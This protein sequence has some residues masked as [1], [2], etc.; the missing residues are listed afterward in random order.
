MIDGLIS[1]LK[2]IQYT[3]LLLSLILFCTCQTPLSIGLE[4]AKKQL[5]IVVQLGLASNTPN[6]ISKYLTSED[7]EEFVKTRYF[8]RKN[9]VDSSSVNISFNLNIPN[10]ILLKKYGT[11]L[12]FLSKSA[13][14]PSFDN[15]TN[16]TSAIT[17]NWYELTNIDS[18]CK[19]KKDYGLAIQFKTPKQHGHSPISESPLKP[20]DLNLLVVKENHID[21]KEVAEAGITYTHSTPSL[22]L[23]RNQLLARDIEESLKSHNILH[24]YH[25]GMLV[26]LSYEAI[27]E[28]MEQIKIYPDYVMN[29]QESRNLEIHNN[30]SLLGKSSPVLNLPLKNPTRWQNDVSLFIPIELECEKVNLSRKVEEKIKGEKIPLDHQ[31]DF[32]DLFPELY[33]VLKDRGNYT[34]QQLTDELNSRLKDSQKQRISI[35]SSDFE[36]FDFI[37]ICIFII[38]S[39]RLYFL[40]YFWELSKQQNFTERSV[41]WTFFIPGAISSMTWYS[42]LVIPNLAIIFSFKNFQMD[43][44]LSSVFIIVCVFLFIS[45]CLISN[46]VRNKLKLKGYKKLL[47]NKF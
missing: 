19:I 30:N 23:I 33:Q 35:F 34:V 7:K 45:E 24:N 5:Q 16:L 12:H 41:A 26:A 9:T 21:I 25:N 44:I 38:N 4:K 40:V 11:N 31:S 36:V 46:E 3:I 22:R 27:S 2:R 6:L 18:T 28:H 32:K 10:W 42:I 14:L 39:F 29:I 15:N 47:N 13:N 43:S 8:S 37:P 17:N 20:E 1:T